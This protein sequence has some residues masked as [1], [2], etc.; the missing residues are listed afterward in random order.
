MPG[1]RASVG[2]RRFQQALSA[3]EQLVRVLGLPA[4]AL[5][6]A[7]ALFGSPPDLIVG[8]D[9]DLVAV[10]LDDGG[11]G[12]AFGAPVVTPPGSTGS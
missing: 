12:G 11:A 1:L 5:G 10:T 2:S 9:G 8:R 7:T 6:A 3:R 4:I